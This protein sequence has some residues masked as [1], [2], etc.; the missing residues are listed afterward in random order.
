MGKVW[1][2]LLGM[3]WMW[4]QDA[5]MFVCR[6]VV[7]R[8]GCMCACGMFAVEK[9]KHHNGAGLPGASEWS[10]VT[11]PPAPVPLCD[12]CCS[13]TQL[14]LPLIH[15]HMEK[16]TPL[17]STSIVICSSLL[18][19]TFR[20]KTRCS[21]RGKRDLILSAGILI[22]A[23]MGRRNGITCI[24]GSIMIRRVY[25]FLVDFKG[26]SCIHIHYT[27]IKFGVDR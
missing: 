26:Q 22:H 7:W 21:M 15:I 24:D 16:R 17:K 5:C 4:C 12:D 23:R 14:S 3:V 2:L 25:Y 10:S 18:I 6:C 20:N 19:V 13:A 1:M 27:V 8:M 9:L 11:P